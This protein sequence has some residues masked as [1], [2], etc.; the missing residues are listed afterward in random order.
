MICGVAV[1]GI[2]AEMA[3]V[4]KSAGFAGAHSSSSST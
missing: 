1:H 2:G 3:S 4:L